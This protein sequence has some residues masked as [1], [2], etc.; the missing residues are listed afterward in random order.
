MDK[1]DKQ[2]DK[3]GNPFFILL[4]YFCIVKSSISYLIL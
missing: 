4:Q 3:M 2:M 1:M